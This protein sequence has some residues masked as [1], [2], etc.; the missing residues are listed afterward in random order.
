MFS[1]WVVTLLLLHNSSRKHFVLKKKNTFIKIVHILC[2]A[3]FIY[4][5]K[6]SLHQA[7]AKR[8]QHVN[9][10]CHNIVGRN[11]LRAFGHC[12]AMCWVLLAQV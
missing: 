12:V 10:T 3:C 9:A 6:H 1:V 5:T 8:S 7:P 11:M 4:L 2:M